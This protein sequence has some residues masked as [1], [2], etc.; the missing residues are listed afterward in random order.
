MRRRNPRFTALLRSL[1]SLRDR[2]EVPGPVRHGNLA[3]SREHW[4]AEGAAQ[5][6]S[7]SRRLRRCKAERRGITREQDGRYAQKCARGCKVLGREE[8]SLSGDP[9]SLCSC[10]KGKTAFFLSRALLFLNGIAPVRQ[11]RTSRGFLRGE[12]PVE[13]KS[14]C[15]S[16]C[17]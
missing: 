3:A 1:L 5:S 16:G 7:S 6:P 17:V 2:S 15:L 8:R 13:Q 9:S 10:V 11:S 4:E 14:G 12:W